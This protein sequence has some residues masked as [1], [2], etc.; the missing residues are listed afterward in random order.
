MVVVECYLRPQG[1]KEKKKKKKQKQT[2][3][4]IGEVGKNQQNQW[5]WSAMVGEK[6]TDLMFW[7]ACSSSSIAI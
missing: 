5:S 7:K 3:M 4:V 2:K 6:R 1:E